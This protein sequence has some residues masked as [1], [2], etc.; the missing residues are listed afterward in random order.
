MS[1]SSDTCRHQSTWYRCRL[2]VVRRRRAAGRRRPPGSHGCSA[3][4]SLVYSEFTPKPSAVSFRRKPCHQWRSAAKNLRTAV[5]AVAGEEISFAPHQE[6][7]KQHFLE[8]PHL[9]VLK[10]SD[11][12]EG[13]CELVSMSTV[14]RCHT[15]HSSDVAA[16][17]RGRPSAGNCRQVFEIHK[18][19]R[20]SQ[21]HFA[22]LEKF[23]SFLSRWHS[24]PLSM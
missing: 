4:W 22:M 13:C 7:Q 1:N 10:D 11:I 18:A 20:R 2:R 14:A 12:L 21:H 17:G 9:L 19:V 24:M 15:V 6:T 3:R 23:G 8:P 5:V 16:A